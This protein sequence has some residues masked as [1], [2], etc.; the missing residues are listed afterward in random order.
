MP[1]VNYD[2]RFKQL[3]KKRISISERFEYMS[4]CLNFTDK[5]TE[6]IRES[7]GILAANLEAILDHIYWDKLI[8]DPWLSKWFRDDTGKIAK[9]CF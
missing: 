2:K 3:L 4:Q 5:D 8:N 9:E 1:V 7:K 6:A